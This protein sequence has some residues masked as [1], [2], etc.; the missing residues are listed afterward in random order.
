MVAIWV[1]Y[2]LALRSRRALNFNPDQLTDIVALIL[3]AGIVGGRL[4]FVIQNFSYFNTH[5]V[6]T[7]RLTT[8]GLSIHGALLIISLAL[9]YYAKQKKLSFLKL[10]DHLV[11]PL[12][13]GQIIGR[14]GNYFNQELFG[15]PTELPWKLAIDPLHRPTGYF[16]NFYFHPTFLYEMLLN[17]IALL[18]VSRLKQ[19]REGSLS[20][21]Y[22]LL[23]AVNRFIVEIFRISD[24]YLFNLSLAQWI[25]LVII[26][27]CGVIYRKYYANKSTLSKP[28]SLFFNGLKTKMR[29]SE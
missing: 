2:A 3:G 20:L 26:I 17:A 16:S 28:I 10:T 8:G 4:G 18:F 29:K 27:G 5:P 6:D 14:L 1:A 22:L 11:I 9:F 25:S 23:F 15:Y 13:A 12:L 24:R 7:I 21:I 19:K